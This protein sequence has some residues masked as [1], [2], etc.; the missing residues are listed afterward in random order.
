VAFYVKG[1]PK[2]LNL[3]I[4]KSFAYLTSCVLLFYLGLSN[5]LSQQT[6][7]NY[8]ETSHCVLSLALVVGLESRVSSLG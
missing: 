3:L 4:V 6:D 2:N 7:S 1:R 5:L 8:A